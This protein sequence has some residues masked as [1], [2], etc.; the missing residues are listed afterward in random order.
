MDTAIALNL[1]PKAVKD[2]LIQED[3]NAW[4]QR[5]DAL[6][7]IKMGEWDEKNPPPAT[8]EQLAAWANERKAAVG[9]QD[10]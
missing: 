5:L 4:K 2:S 8:K 10:R 3:L 1:V 7:K 6:Q 9:R